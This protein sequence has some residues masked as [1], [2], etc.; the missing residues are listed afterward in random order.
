MINNGSIEVHGEVIKP[1]LIELMSKINSSPLNYRHAGGGGINWRLAD[2][3][4]L[5]PTQFEPNQ[6]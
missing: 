1:N 2:K 5:T 6:C 3:I 4:L